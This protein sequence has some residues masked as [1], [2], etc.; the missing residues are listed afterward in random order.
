M[1]SAHDFKFHPA[2][3]FL[4]ALNIILTQKNWHPIAVAG[5]PTTVCDFSQFAS[6][7]VRAGAVQPAIDQRGRRPLSPRS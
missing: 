3:L 2:E 1:H 7:R 5:G 4:I 6:M